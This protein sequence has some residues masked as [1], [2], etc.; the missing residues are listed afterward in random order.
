MKTTIPNKILK[1]TPDYVAMLPGPPF[2]FMLN[3]V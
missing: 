3:G 2:N 1:Y